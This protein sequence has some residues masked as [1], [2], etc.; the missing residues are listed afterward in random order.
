MAPAAAAPARLLDRRLTRLP[1]PTRRP[2]TPCTA[3]LSCEAASLLRALLQRDPTRRLGFGPTGSADVRAHAFFRTIDWKR[4]EAREL[5][6]P[7]LPTVG[8]A[9][10]IANFDKIWTDLPVQVRVGGGGWPAGRVRAGGWVWAWAWA[11]EGSAGQVA[12]HVGSGGATRAGAARAQR[13]RRPTRVAPLPSPDRAG[14][15]VRDAPRR[16]G[17]VSP[18]RG[19]H[20][21]G[22]GVR[23]E[24]GSGRRRAASPA[25]PRVR[26][27]PPAPRPGEPRWLLLFAVGLNTR[28][29]MQGGGQWS[30]LSN[31]TF[32]CG[33]A[34]A[35]VFCC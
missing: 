9:E 8:S 16:R 28:S 1:R 4:L 3:Y 31:R 33:H 5:P 6:S 19:V 12:L 21:R 2:P 22:P 20:L 27:G 25:H 15:A 29:R 18:L 24:P 14:L 26:A 30:A 11:R 10:C 7:F 35:P 13:P 34:R 23:S 17:R 32:A